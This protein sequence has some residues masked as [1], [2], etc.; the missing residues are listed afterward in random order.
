M[1]RVRR[2][3]GFVQHM[4]P[5][6][7]MVPAGLGGFAALWFGVAALAVDGPLPLGWRAGL[8]AASLTLFTFLLRV[9]DEL[10][11]AETDV[12]LGRA[13]DPR[14]KDR[15]IVT[16]A[17][18]IEDIR[19]LRW[20]VT[21][22]LFAVNAPLATDPTSGAA[23]AVAFG[24]TWLSFKWFFWPAVSRNL[25]LAFATHNPLSLV[26]GCY[27]AALFVGE[28]GT[29]GL[30][31]GEVS[32]LLFGLWMPVAA[33]E[34]SRKIRLPQDETDYQ[35]YSKMLGWR[36]AAVLPA[37][38]VAASAASLVPVVLATGLGRGHAAGL[39]AAALV[40]VGATALL[41]V[42]PTSGRTNLR[43]Y[44]ELYAL[45]CNVGLAVSLA[46]D[47]GITLE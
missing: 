43:P 5:P 19:A 8:G 37:V 22:L 3:A 41:Q 18:L 34:T 23:F 33:W 25:L 17:V 10:K 44:C 12:R 24:M 47:R 4:F 2:L 28:H 7:V 36:V 32:L 46:V 39:I 9:Y 27:V 31:W 11:D 15:P 45:V 35:T 38:F 14:Y 6:A 1:S 20:W 40:P 13:G 26:L 42:A 30:R 29:A 16:G 21:G